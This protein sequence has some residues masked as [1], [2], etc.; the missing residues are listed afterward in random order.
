LEARDHNE[1]L[2]LWHPS[3]IL[4]L[5]V[6]DRDK[7][8]F[9][10]TENLSILKSM[11]SV[12]TLPCRIMLVLGPDKHGMALRADHCSDLLPARTLY[13]EFA[14]V[15]LLLVKI[16]EINRPILII[17]YHHRRM[18]P[19]QQVE[20]PLLGVGGVPWTEIKPVKLSVDE[21]ERI[22]F[23]RGFHRETSSNRQGYLTE[24]T[25]LVDVD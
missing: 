6:E 7:I 25:I 23:L 21:F 13:H 1:I 17:L 9:P 16:V 11:F 2:A 5:I 20:R 22:R 12:I 18:L 4:N 15:D 14:P 3:Y 8:P 24:V 19:G 10:A